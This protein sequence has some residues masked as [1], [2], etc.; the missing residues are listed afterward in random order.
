[1]SISAENAPPFAVGGPQ[2]R[3]ERQCFMMFI[4]Q[5]IPVFQPLLQAEESRAVVEA[6]ELGWLGMGSYVGQFEEAIRLQI[7][8]A[9][10]HVVAVST[11]HAAI[12]LALLLQGVGPGDEVITPS[13]N[14][15][16]DL[17]AILATGAEPVFCDVDPVTLCI[18]VDDVAALV[19]SRT[20]VVIAT[21]YFCH[22]ADHDGLKALAHERGF[23]VL[24]DAA[25]SFGSLY[26]GRQVGSFSDVTMFSFDAVK[27][28]TCIDGG[29][30]VVRSQDEADAL[31]EMRLIGMGQ[32]SSIMYQNQRAWTYDVSRLG[33]RYHLANLHAALGLSQLAKLDEI[34]TTRVAAC[35][36]YNERLSDVPGLTLPQTDFSDVTP[37]LYYVRVPAGQRS[38]FR[39]YLANAGVD[40]GV[41]WQPGHW[42]SLFRGY[43][44][45]DLKVTE[46]VGQEIVS[47]P[48]HSLMARETVDTVCDAIISFAQRNS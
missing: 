41:H 39:A 3:A 46:Q 38:D 11:G 2:S 36:R 40:T 21:D 6:L 30:L 44:R 47:L 26:Q 25:H 18:D 15:I 29:A 45:G 7:G 27:T 14:N 10:L 9:D 24:H 35:R 13:F 12:H 1:M 43:R 28:I 4:V 8:A 33:F 37:F 5:R 48:L 20:K 17:Q 42:F 31:R 23:R 16:A 34:T 32:Q 22:L 19:S